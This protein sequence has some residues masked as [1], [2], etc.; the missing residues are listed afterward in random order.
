MLIFIFISISTSINRNYGENH[1]HE[2]IIEFPEITQ[3]Y[4]NWTIYK[5]ITIGNVNRTT[6]IFV[7]I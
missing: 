3:A 2:K 5:H 4:N 6:M 1:R 7:I